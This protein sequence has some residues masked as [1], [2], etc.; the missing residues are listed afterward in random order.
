MFIGL[1]CLVI[2]YNYLLSMIFNFLSLC[3]FFH[4]LL[5][6]Q[7]MHDKDKLLHSNSPKIVRN[8]Q[9]K[10]SVSVQSEC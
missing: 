4:F 10:I 6:F 7:L 5:I 3:F 2:L 1:M 9:K 8:G